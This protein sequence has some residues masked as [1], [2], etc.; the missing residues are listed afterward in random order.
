MWVIIISHKRWQLAKLDGKYSQKT[1]NESWR[2]ANC[3]GEDEFT[4]GRKGARTNLIDKK[5]V[6]VDSFGALGW[7]KEDKYSE[8]L[9]L[10]ECGCNY[11]LALLV[12]LHRFPISTHPPIVSNREKKCA[13]CTHYRKSG[14][15]EG[16]EFTPLSRLPYSPITSPSPSTA[17]VPFFSNEQSYLL[18]MPAPRGD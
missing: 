7:H 6:R 5:P 3:R 17:S 13:C 9:T 14:P 16:N 1:A 18:M 8:S 11:I 10:L 15:L 2:V 12:W 4:G